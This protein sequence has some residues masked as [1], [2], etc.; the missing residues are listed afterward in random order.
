MQRPAALA[1]ISK[2]SGPVFRHAGLQRDVRTHMQAPQAVHASAATA[3]A[4]LECRLAAL[5][6]SPTGPFP[7]LPLLKDLYVLR[8]AVGVY[9]KIIQRFTAQVRCACSQA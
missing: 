1:T 8:R 7:H 9:E 5:H 4:A 6:P 3:P 2:V